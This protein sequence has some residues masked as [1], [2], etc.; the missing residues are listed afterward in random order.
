MRHAKGSRE[1]RSTVA[2]ALAALLIAA[3]FASCNRSPQPKG[4]GK[5]GGSAETFV[6]PDELWELNNQGV[7]YMEQ[8]DLGGG[9]PKAVPIFEEIVRRWPDWYPGKFNLAVALVNFKQDDAHLE[10]AKLLL[11]EVLSKNDRDPRVHYTIGFVLQYQ[12]RFDEARPYFERVCLDLDP[13]DAHSWMRLGD[14]LNDSFT[15]DAQP[16]PEGIT[17]ESCYERAFSLNPNIASA[18]YKLSQLLVRSGQ[19]DRATELRE[20]FSKLTAGP[21]DAYGND[22]IWSG[23]LAEVVGVKL[24]PPRPGD[25]PLPVFDSAPATFYLSKEARWATADDLAAAGCGGLLSRIRE[26]FGAGIAAFDADKDGDLDLFLPA[27]AVQHGRLRD[28]LFRNDGNGRF[29]DV[30]AV[31]GLDGPRASVGC[32]IGDFDCDHLPDLCITALGG[33]VLFRSTKELKFENV[34]DQAGVALVE[35]LSLSAYF[36]DVDHDGDLDLLVSQ[37]G[38]LASAGEMFQEEPFGGGAQ[39]AVFMNIGKARNAGDR[40][41]NDMPPLEVG[42]QRLPSDTSP[43]DEVAPTVGFA[44]ADIDSDRDLDLIE[45]NDNKPCRVLLNRRLAKWDGIAIGAEILPP[46]TYNGAVTADFNCDLLIDLLLPGP[47]GAAVCLLNDQSTAS[48]DRLPTLKIAS[49]DLARLR[50]VQVV[51]SDFDGWLDVVGLTSNDSQIALGLNRPRGL[52]S[53]PEW[54]AGLVDTGHPSQGVLVADLCGTGWPQILIARQGAAPQL[55]ATQG[56]GNNWLAVHTAGRREKTTSY[57]KK[58]PRSNL[59]G[60]GTRVIVHSGPNSVVWDGCSQ[61]AGLSQSLLPLLVGLGERSKA[62]AVRL[63]WPSGVEQAELNLPGNRSHTIEEVRRR[64]TSCPL[65]FAWDG[66]RFQFVTDFLG[67]GGIGYLIEPGVYSVPDPDEDISIDSRL[68]KVDENNCYVLK[69]AEP[70]DEM[71][72]LDAAWLEVVDHAPDVTVVADE[73]FNP[74]GAHASG[75]RIVFRDRAYPVA[76]RDHRGRDMRDRILEWDR[77]TVDEFA[78]STRW[79]G[80]AEN[81]HLDLDFGLAFN[82]LKPDEPVALVLAGWIEYPYSQT[83]WAAS[84][85]GVHLEPPVLK[86]QNAHGEWETLIPSMGYPAGLPRLMT[87][88]LTGKLP[89]TVRGEDSHDPLPCRLRI[90]TNMEIYWDQI[91]AVRPEPTTMLRRTLLKPSTAELDYRGYLQEYSP[92]GRE[93]KLFD[94]H[95]I[96]S[97]PLVDLEGT[98]TPYGPVRSLVLEQDDQFVLINAGDEVTLTFDANE[99]PA[100]PHGWTRSFVLRT[101]GYCKDTD[102]FNQFDRTVEPL[103]GGKLEEL[104]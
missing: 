41:G 98:R 74:D 40:N 33:N 86:W 13:N 71:T 58:Y 91:F 60:I 96:I 100:L 101:F 14:C 18:C 15:A 79:I 48:G 21:H 12:G 37:Y 66:R 5:S 104:K 78:R 73:R 57:D 38:P 31:A 92:D 22:Y 80:Y 103:P 77:H 19:T 56:N 84:T 94:Y 35:T 62:E 89:A 76:A 43:W 81:H 93:P 45:I 63:R 47:N 49:T 69:I 59:D 8:F 2:C 7:A 55:L 6:A 24:P 54:L 97:V 99:L 85:A 90:E 34:T 17:A 88:D 29:T 102:L 72:Y 83:N 27:S 65:L 20:R 52:L 16:G 68:L 50:S 70:M 95:Q 51:D 87:L 61:Y 11:R 44:A 39:N 28:T 53:R 25:K 30:T 67:G 82:G 9:F 1:L 64:D 3:I 23:S 26:R 36:F 75:A 32:A 42:F 46:G 4:T 10:R